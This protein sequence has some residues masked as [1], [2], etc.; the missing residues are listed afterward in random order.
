MSVRAFVLRLRPG[1]WP[2]Q[3][4][5]G[6]HF[7]AHLQVFGAESHSP[8]LGQ[9]RAGESLSPTSLGLTTPIRG[10]Y[11]TKVVPSMVPTGIRLT[12]LLP[13]IRQ[14]A[15]HAASGAHPRMPTGH[16]L[17]KTS[18]LDNMT[19]AVPPFTWGTVLR[20]FADAALDVVVNGTG[21]VAQMTKHCGLK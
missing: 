21:S 16:D 5:G 1:V 11:P 13:R 4:S 20:I 15:V 9:A 19:A 12:G 10:T 8:R 18:A 14:R 7:R 17:A 2:P 3:G 6:R